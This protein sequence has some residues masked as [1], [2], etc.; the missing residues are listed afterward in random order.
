[1]EVNSV[2]LKWNKISRE[3]DSNKANV[4]LVLLLFIAIIV[5]VMAASGL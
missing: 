3:Y 4:Y 2:F 5:L 1:M